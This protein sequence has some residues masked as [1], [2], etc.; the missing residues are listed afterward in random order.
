MPVREVY[1]Q[2]T[3]VRLRELAD[4]HITTSVE[5]K[6]HV[7]RNFFLSQRSRKS[8]PNVISTTHETYFFTLWY[9]VKQRAKLTSC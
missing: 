2:F 8:P 6:T 5:K 9:F 4:I 1:E 7:S 3:G